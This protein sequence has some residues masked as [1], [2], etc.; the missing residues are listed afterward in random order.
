MLFNT[1]A[2]LRALIG[3]DPQR[4]QQ[5]LDHMIAYL[6]ETL[7][8]SRATLHPLRAEFHRLHDYLELMTVRMGSRLHYTLD[9]PDELADQSMPPLLLQP[10]VE[11]AIRHGLEPKLEGG[12]I[13][14]RARRA[15]GRMTLEVI[16]TGVGLSKNA[17]RLDGFGL[18]HVR[19]RLA[20]TY[21]NKGAV[22]LVT[23]N[24]HGTVAKVTFPCEV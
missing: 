15:A 9:L 3:T 2:N 20:A 7:S 1:L 17:E 19:E 10:M 4:A 23:G 14:V 16:D 8:A 12:S 5:M 6:R 18:M 22:E 24:D 21:G 11:N 13:T